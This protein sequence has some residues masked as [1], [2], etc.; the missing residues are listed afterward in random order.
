MRWSEGSEK[1]PLGV[2]SGKELLAGR[3]EGAQRLGKPIAAFLAIYPALCTGL[4]NNS[5]AR[6][7]NQKKSH[8]ELIELSRPFFKLYLYKYSNGAKCSFYCIHRPLHFRTSSWKTLF[9][10]IHLTNVFKTVFNLKIFLC[11]IIN[12][13]YSSRFQSFCFLKSSFTHFFSM[14]IFLPWSSAHIPPSQWCLAYQ[15]SLLNHKT[16]VY[17]IVFSVHNINQILI[18]VM[19]ALLIQFHS[20]I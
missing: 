6:L 5:I 4:Q 19:N 12:H 14:K 10:P 9:L 3:R 18:N 1:F 15:L 7:Q 16:C 11:Q 2:F 8:Y 17:A 13:S 20:V